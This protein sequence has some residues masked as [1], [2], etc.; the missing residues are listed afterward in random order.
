M[1]AEA[2]DS[3]TVGFVED[4][5]E[6]ARRLA[7][8]DVEPLG[9]V[10]SASNGTMLCQLGDPADELFAIYKPEQYERPLWDF[11]GSL[12]LREVAA[13][14]I[15]EF[16]GWGVVPP[17][18][19]RD[20]PKGP[21]SL[22]L[23]VPH[24]PSQHYFVLVEDRAHDMELTRLAVFDMA[25]NNADRKGGHV[26]LS[27]REPRLYGIDNGLCFHEEPKLRTVVWDLPHV[28]FD[29][30]WLD[31]LC[32]LADALEADEPIGERM[33]ELLTITEVRVLAER[34]RQVAGM[35]NMPDIHPDERWYP[36]PPV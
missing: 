1:A 36:W 23:F 28:P 22:Q 4:H 34:C 13:Y 14:E 20:G 30:V 10:S 21:G 12:Y 31:D 2:F 8:D 17:T 26:L 27:T 32:R 25:T 9:F 16:L 24:A 11:P 29:R 5:A 18:V 6:G 3:S 15:S 19:L 35:T 33:H 7:E